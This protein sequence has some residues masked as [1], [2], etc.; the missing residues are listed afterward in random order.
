MNFIK[1][2]SVLFISLLLAFSAG[3]AQ[4][5]KLLKMPAFDSQK[6][7]ITA[8]AEKFIFGEPQ[9]QFEYGENWDDSLM[10][11]SLSPET[12]GFFGENI[13]A[14][15]FHFET[16]AQE[17]Q[18]YAMSFDIVFYD[19]DG[20]NYYEKTR[21]K[22]IVHINAQLD[23][24]ITTPISYSVVRADIPVF[25]IA[26]GEGFD[27]YRLLYRKND[28]IDHSFSEV[29]IQAALVHEWQGESSIDAQFFNAEAA[30][31]DAYHHFTL[32]TEFQIESNDNR[33]MN[34][35][36]HN[37][38]NEKN[39]G[40]RCGIDPDGFLRF[41]STEDGGSLSLKSKSII[42]AHHKYQLTLVINSN[43]SR[44]YLDGQL[45]D[46][47]HGTVLVS[48]NNL[49]LGDTASLVD[50]HMAQAFAGTFFN[51]YLYERALNHAETVSLMSDPSRNAG[52][53]QF[54]ASDTPE[55]RETRQKSLFKSKGSILGNLGTWTTGLTEYGT[56]SKVDGEN[57]KRNLLGEYTLRLEVFDAEGNMIFDE[58][59]VSVGR[60]I[61]SSSGGSF[62][63][64]DKKVKV[65][66]D[67]FSSLD[68]ENFVGHIKPVATEKVIH[69]LPDDQRL[70]TPIYS[71][72][73]PSVAT[74]EPI[75]FQFNSSLF[76][77]GYNTYQKMFV[78]N[79]KEKNW[80][81]FKQSK[82]S[83]ANGDLEILSDKI[84]SD[85]ALFAIFE[86]LDTS[87]GFLEAADSQELDPAAVQL[88]SDTHPLLY[89]NSFETLGYTRSYNGSNGAVINILSESND[90]FLEMS[91]SNR[92]TLFSAELYGQTYSSK[93]Y[94][95]LG[96]K[97]KIKP[98]VFVD[99]F[100]YHK[101][102]WY[103]FKLTDGGHAEWTGINPI[104]TSKYAFDDNQWHY[105]SFNIYDEIKKYN[106]YFSTNDILID[107]VIIADVNHRSCG[108]SSLTRVYDDA[109]YYIDDLY[110]GRGGKTGERASLSFF[111]PGSANGYKIKTL[112]A[113]EHPFKAQTSI[114]KQLN[115][116]AN[117]GSEDPFYDRVDG[118]VL[119]E[120]KIESPES[121]DITFYLEGNATVNFYMD[122]SLLL[123]KSATL[124]EATH[125]LAMTRGIKKNIKITASGD[126]P[127]SMNIQW[128]GE[129][130]S[131]KD[132]EQK[133]LYPDKTI[134]EES[135]SDGKVYVEEFYNINGGSVADLV[136]S[137]HYPNQPSAVKW[138][139]SLQS[140]NDI[141]ENFG[142]VM[143]S[144]LNIPQDGSYK[145]YITGDDMA[146]LYMSTN[147]ESEAWELIA[148]S[149]AYAKMNEFAK[150]PEQT[151]H[152]IRL[153][154][155]QS[156]SLKVL[157]KEKFGGDHVSVA[158]ST[159]EGH[160][161]NPIPASVLT[162]YQP[163]VKAVGSGLFVTRY[164]NSGFK[165]SGFES[166]SEFE[167]NA[168][169]S[170]FELNPLGKLYYP[171]SISPLDSARNELREDKW[172]VLNDI[173]Q[174][175]INSGISV[176]NNKYLLHYEAAESLNI[177]S[178]NQTLFFTEDSSVPQVTSL[179][180]GLSYKAEDA[181]FVETEF[182]LERDSLVNIFMSA[183]GNGGSSD[184]LWRQLDDGEILGFWL[185]SGDGFQANILYQNIQLEA[186]QHTLKL[187]LQEDG[188][189]IEH[190]AV[191]IEGPAWN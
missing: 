52:Y 73:A 17:V 159:G 127:F 110:I 70:L 41:W 89:Y 190:I 121:E 33:Y 39:A 111:D 182:T 153:F 19:V 87:Q 25:G 142:R 34:I 101:D 176:V 27:H 186:G 40:W 125:T 82:L 154:E 13:F 169:I 65:L 72:L 83:N 156:L 140:P 147:A 44:L 37:S 94:P 134:L 88:A 64:S 185:E 139:D 180:L 92:D 160:F 116:L 162:K 188:V 10:T 7:I 31:N 173:E 174:Q 137:P 42:E 166:F 85:W 167:I 106:G 170:N 107:K 168:D 24:Q 26:K 45:E 164:N 80:E 74:H 163:D 129:S 77:N 14:Y 50:A 71:L 58:V 4:Q 126:L 118:A 6:H 78:Y 136:L 95:Y 81:W 18:N 117:A 67:G 123:S 53:I 103:C 114:I 3:M 68:T 38:A 100:V 187:Y 66:F 141:D 130:F 59:P 8:E 113:G 172:L 122:E 183:K 28:H 109:K 76:S 30:E 35:L 150:Y 144:S 23:A 75:R 61:T 91:L 97:Y 29:D 36:F 104:Y 161:E 84:E 120:G 148:S 86:D 93:E 63:S 60:V 181:H 2:L 128:S 16:H 12:P 21:L 143:Y 9:I 15:A 62:Y 20:Q 132:I 189:S 22:Y 57:W 151:S 179:D 152:S 69:L 32:A 96:L 149:P 47:G 158:W 171:F 146:E 115:F 145:F 157:H 99:L 119:F 79:L 165:S 46:S 178:D 138:L 177:H 105:I 43:D 48:Q 108:G 55:L 112:A 90:S 102:K 56:P 98:N 135:E 1:K 51:L 155:G 124:A 5:K 54:W 49:V 184:S 131:R 11:V 175:T 133:Y 191:S